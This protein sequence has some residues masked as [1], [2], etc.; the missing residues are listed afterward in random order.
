MACG[1][2]DVSRDGLGSGPKDLT[3]PIPM[4]KSAEV[5]TTTKTGK[6]SDR[7]DVYVATRGVFDEGAKEGRFDFRGQG[8]R[9]L[10]KAIVQGMEMADDQPTAVSVGEE[11][12]SHFVGT[13][14][15]TPQGPVLVLNPKGENTGLMRGSGVAG[16]VVEGWHPG[17]EG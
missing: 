12:Y 8:Y 17:K 16:A 1:N 4:L 15:Q 7:L 3:H 2:N 6:N 13:I 9:E 11:Q 14:E 5:W 10:A